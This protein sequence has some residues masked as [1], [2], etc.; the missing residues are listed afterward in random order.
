M[1]NI[2]CDINVDLC[3]ANKNINLAKLKIKQAINVIDH[4]CMNRT[5]ANFELLQRSKERLTR[6]QDNLD[7]IENK[8]LS[9]STIDFE[10]LD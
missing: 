2:S 9:F 5:V 8:L 10:I 1:K 6:Q 3:N 4:A 7:E